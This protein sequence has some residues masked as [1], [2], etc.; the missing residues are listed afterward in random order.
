MGHIW[1]NN[2]M[3]N[4]ESEDIK[5]ARLEMCY[6]YLETDSTIGIVKFGESGYYKTDYSANRGNKDLVEHLNARLGVSKA[7]AEAMMILSM[8]DGI[9]ADSFE[10][11]FDGL[12]TTLKEKLG[13]K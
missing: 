4:C 9:T 2:I 8:N 1:Y 10:E 6:I 5:M 7:E 12:V 3:I 13:D 11:R